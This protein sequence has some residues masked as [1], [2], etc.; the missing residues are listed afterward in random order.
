MILKINHRTLS[1]GAVSVKLFTQW[2]RF[3]LNYT[4]VR[5]ESEL[6]SHLR[7]VHCTKKLFNGI[8]ASS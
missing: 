6:M 8:K 4:I 2:V 5:N 3:F 7:L 1:D